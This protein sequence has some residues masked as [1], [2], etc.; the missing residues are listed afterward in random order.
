MLYERTKLSQNKEK[1]LAMLQ[2]KPD[3]GTF[4]NIIHDAYIFEFLGLKQQEVLPEKE[5][6]QALHDHLLQFLL[7]LGKGFCFEA[8][9]KRTA[10]D[11][12][13]ILLI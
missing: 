13:T 11:M 3:T 6:E 7:E 8:R 4:T 9:Q 12:S 1:L 2:A 5:L 10:I